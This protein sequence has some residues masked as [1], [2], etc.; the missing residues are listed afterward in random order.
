MST[1]LPPSINNV[2]N[3]STYLATVASGA[4]VTTASAMVQSLT[5]IAYSFTSDVGVPSHF[6]IQTSQVTTL[7]A[8]QAKFSSLTYT[9]GGSTV[10]IRIPDTLCLLLQAW[11]ETKQPIPLSVVTNASGLSTIDLTP[12]GFANTPNVQACCVEAVAGQGTNAV[13]ISVSNTSLT[14]KTYRSQPILLLSTSPVI[15]VAA[16]CH[17]LI[18]TNG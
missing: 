18:T 17:V 14:L 3:L 7:A 5:P 15:P 12:Y 13:I 11:K 6:G 9:E 8:S 2:S 1:T 16:T 10:G 4:P